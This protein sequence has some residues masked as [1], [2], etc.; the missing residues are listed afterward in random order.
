MSLRDHVA[1]DD[2]RTL[3]RL[4]RLRSRAAFYIYSLT[5]TLQLRRA[6]TLRCYTCAFAMTPVQNRAADP[7]PFTTGGALRILS[8]Q[9]VLTRSRQ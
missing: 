8:N 7:Q 2:L 4:R 6:A 1:I 5:L 9:V 3:V